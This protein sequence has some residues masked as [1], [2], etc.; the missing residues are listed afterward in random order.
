ML[1]L[2]SKWANFFRNSP[3]TGM[4]YTV[5]SVKLANGTQ[6]D[7]VVVDGG[8]ITSV[9]GKDVIPFAE[10]EIVEF[11]VTHDKTALRR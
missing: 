5:C 3:E 8:M 10:A 6:F 9:D 7:R 11:I 4:G 1:A 2:S